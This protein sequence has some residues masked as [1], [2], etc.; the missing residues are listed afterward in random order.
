MPGV[1][2]KI[3][4][5]NDLVMAVMMHCMKYSEV[6]PSCSR[7]FEFVKDVRT[8]EEKC[9]LLNRA[10]QLLDNDGVVPDLQEI[11]EMVDLWHDLPRDGWEMH[12]R[13]A[14]AN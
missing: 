7:F 1:P 14:G 8:D 4:T 13:Q 2:V 10:E 3:Y 6:S 11:S 9:A 12:E 5:Q